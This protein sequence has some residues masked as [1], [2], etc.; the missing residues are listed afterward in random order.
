MT[1]ARLDSLAWAA[2][3]NALPWANAAQSRCHDTVG[4]T[5]GRTHHLTWM[6]TMK[7]MMA[8]TMT[9]TVMTAADLILALLM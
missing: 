4:S 9:M 7:T 8:T 6:S 2:R 3:S 5:G 1:A